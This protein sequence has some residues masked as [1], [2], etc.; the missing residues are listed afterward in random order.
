MHQSKSAQLGRVEAIDAL[1]GLAA[2]VVVLYHARDLLW[3]GTSEMFR[4]YRFQP[5]LEAWLGYLTGPLS[6]GWLG[7]T[8][9][10]V[11]S[12]YCIHRRGAQRLADNPQAGLDFPRFARRRFW[13][14]YPTYAAALL[15]TGLIDW[16]VLKMVGY[17]DVW[18][19]D[20]RWTT[21][22]ASFAGLQGFAAPTYGSN[23]VFWTLAM[24]IHLYLAYPVLF[25]ISKRYGAV[26][27]LIVTF[28]ISATFAFADILFGLQAAVPYHFLRGP[29]F[30]PYWF[31]W[32][33]GFYLAEVQA[34]RAFLPRRNYMRVLAAVGLGGGLALVALKHLEASEI[35]WSLTFG[36]IVW[37]SLGGRGRQFWDSLIGRILAFIGV[38]SYSLYAIHYP[39]LLL[40]K[41]YA[42]P[43][44]DKPFSLFMAIC[45]VCFALVA[46]WLFFQ[47]VERWT[48]RWPP[49]RPGGRGGKAETL[50]AEMLKS[51]GQETEDRR[52]RTEDRGGNAE[53]LKR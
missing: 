19:D 25:W 13:R 14:I 24:E 2:F 52:Q 28:S 40:F 5:R 48:L 4:R 53:T 26:P 41:A 33:V 37:W 44:G 38:F 34:G 31:T 6:L 17:R 47:V 36:A 22:L 18:M 30:L 39:A 21:L 49:G 20:H 11:L 15:L 10:F 42:L 46:A 35:W 43:K 23:G 8:L 45:G 9:F 16:Y 32:T 12:G 1:R 29:M 51:G 7:V 3:V 50:K 27:V